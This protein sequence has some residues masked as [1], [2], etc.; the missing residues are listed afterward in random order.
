MNQIHST[1]FV[2]P[3][4]ELGGDVD[5][6]PFAYIGEF[7]RVGRGTKLLHHACIEGHTTLGED[8]EIGSFSV[9]GGKPQDLKYKGEP[10]RLEVGSRNQ[11]REC[12]TVN[13]GTVSGG[14]LTRIGDDC[15][16]MAYCHV[17]HDCKIANHVVMANY[18][19]LSGHVTIEDYVILSGMCGVTQFLRIGKHAFIGGMSGIRKDVAPYG[20]LLGDPAEVRGINRVGLK[21]RGFDGE[22][23][24]AVMEAHKIYFESGLEKEQALAELDRRFPQQADVRYFVDFIRKSEKGI[25]R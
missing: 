13:T 14:G 9:L 19:G 4:A 24:E 16:V 18:T 15:L 22:R 11:F 3:K 23:L 1:A 17:A 8:N 12:V 6:G 5:V 21:R 10:T 2:H 25:S 20:I 7:A